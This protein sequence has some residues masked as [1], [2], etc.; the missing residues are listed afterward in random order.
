MKPLCCAVAHTVLST[1]A[2]GS[3]TG[4]AGMLLDCVPLNHIPHMPAALQ[5]HSRCAHLGFKQSFSQ[6][7]ACRRT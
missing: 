7:L 6:T 2:S 5:W 1:D 3:R 4:N